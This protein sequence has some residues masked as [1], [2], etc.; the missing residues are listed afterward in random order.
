MANTIKSATFT[1]AELVKELQDIE[2]SGG[3]FDILALEPC[4]WSQKPSKTG[5]I[6]DKFLVIYRVS[7]DK[8]L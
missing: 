2:K 7:E 1:Q 4:E 6:V 8:A 3:A 5:D